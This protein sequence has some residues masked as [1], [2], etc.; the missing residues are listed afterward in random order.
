MNMNFYK[1]GPEIT[2]IIS[3]YM[4]NDLSNHDKELYHKL[5][6]EEK[7]KYLNNLAICRCNNL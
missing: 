6:E 2:D 4:Y 1:K 3:E 7:I 5:T